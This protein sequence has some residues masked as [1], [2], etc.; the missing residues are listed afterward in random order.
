M[1]INRAIAW[2]A[3][4]TDADAQTLW[5]IKG[6]ASYGAILTGT[7]ASHG[8]P[9]DETPRMDAKQRYGMSNSD[10]LDAHRIAAAA[11]VY[12]QILVS[13][14]CTIFEPVERLN[15]GVRQAIQILVTARQ[16]MTKDRTRVVNA[17]TAVLRSK[18]L[19]MDARKALPKTQIA[20]VAKWRTRKQELVD[21]ERQLAELVQISEAAPLLQEKGFKAISAA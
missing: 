11:L 3:R 14:M 12:V 8:Y 1:G 7:V 19:G 13:R 2:V 20:E 4:G 16:S 9:V 15:D 10:T 18:D 17:L 5:V 21:N 6:A